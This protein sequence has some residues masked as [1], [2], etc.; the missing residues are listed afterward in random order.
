LQIVIEDLLFITVDRI[1]ELK[2]MIEAGA[3]GVVT[4]HRRMGGQY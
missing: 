3:R 2:A 1:V 4:R